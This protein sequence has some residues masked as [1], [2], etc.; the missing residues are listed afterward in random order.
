MATVPSRSASGSADVL[1]ALGFLL[2]RRRPDRHVDRRARLRLHVR[3]VAP[4]G[5]ASRST[6]AARAG[7]RTIFN[8]LGPL[9]NPAGARAQVFGVYSPDLVRTVAEVLAQLGAGAHSSSTAPVASTSSRRAGRTR[10]RGRR[11]RGARP[12]DRPCS[13]S[14]SLPATPTPHRRV[15]GRERRGDP[16]DL[17]GRRRRPARDAILLNAAG[18]IAA[19]GHADDLR[20][21][22]E[23]PVGRSTRAPRSS[24]STSCRVLRRGVAPDGRFTDALRR[25]GSARSPRSSVARRRR[26]D[27]R[28][29]ADPARLAAAYARTGA[30]AVSVLVD[31]LFGGGWDDLRAARV[32]T[33]CRFSR[34]ASSRPRSTSARCARQAQTPSCCCCETSTTPV[35]DPLASAGEL[36]LDT[37]VE[38]HDAEEL[39]RAVALDAPVIGVNARDLSTF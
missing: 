3:P 21:G 34:R 17:R 26:G 20:E 30:A 5:D 25:P 32:A 2:D 23:S 9:T 28:P 11:R 19:A 18:A 1:E 7:T 14:A 15:P 13:I 27:L 4:P 38:A 36:G 10:L 31:E 35:R 12:G 33:A 22:L 16:R 6:R 8:V 24:G 29:D 39:D 37:L